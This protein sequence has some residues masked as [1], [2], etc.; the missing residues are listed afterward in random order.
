MA[1]K[2]VKRCLASFVTREMQI[3]TTMRCYFTPHQNGFNKK[4]KIAH[5][6]EGVEKSEPSYIADGNV[7]CQT[8]WKFLKKFNTELSYDPA[9][10]LLHIYLKELEMDSNSTYTPQ[11]IVALFT[12]AKRW[13]GPHVH[14]WM[15]SKQNVVYAPVEYY[16]AI[17]R[18]ELLMHASI[19][20][21][22]ESIML[23]EK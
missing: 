7:F 8:V 21:K 6:D 9:I 19:G 15:D 1:K 22:L 20:I 5:V 11:V 13:K 18:N 10:L 14:R 2:L 12:I 23:S 4:R 16:L 17:K 3:K